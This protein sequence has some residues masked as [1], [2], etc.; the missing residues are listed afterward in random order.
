MNDCLVLRSLDILFPGSFKQLLIFPKDANAWESCCFSYVF[1]KIMHCLGWVVVVVVVVV[2]AGLG[3]VA[4]IAWLAA[5]S[6]LHPYSNWAFLHGCFCGCVWCSCYK[7]PSL[8][9]TV[10][11]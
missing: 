7:L 2:A 1:C 10:H 9:L 4:V 3:P 8:K 11:T 6:L 5:E